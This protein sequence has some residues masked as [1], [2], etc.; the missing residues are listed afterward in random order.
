MADGTTTPGA[1]APAPSLAEDWPAQAAD[2]IEKYVGQVRDATTGRAI[3]AARALVYGTFA[4]LVGTV[5]VVMLAIAGV[6]LLDAYLPNDWVG[7]DHVWV[8]HA[9]IG[10]V[11]AIAGMWCWSRRKAKAPAKP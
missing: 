8:A 10:G 9:A 4:L 2:A 7:E 5:V 6:R 11:L 1:P 3:T